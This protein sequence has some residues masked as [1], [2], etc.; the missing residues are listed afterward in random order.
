MLSLY[1]SEAWNRMPRHWWRHVRSAAALALLPRPSTRG[2]SNRFSLT[3]VLV[4]FVNHTDWEELHCFCYLLCSLDMGVLKAVFLSSRWNTHPALLCILTKKEQ[5]LFWFVF[6]ESLSST[7]ILQLILC[8]G[9]CTCS[10]P[11]YDTMNRFPRASAPPR[12]IDWWKVLETSRAPSH[13][14]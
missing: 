5:F 11:T 14:F 12:H 2:R 1:K 8:P 3:W 4:R 9:I 6:T 13:Y 10:I 7:N